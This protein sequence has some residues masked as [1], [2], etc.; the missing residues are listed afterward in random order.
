MPEISYKGK[1]YTIFGAQEKET[2]TYFLIC[3]NCEFRWV[4]AQECRPYFA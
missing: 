4:N 3:I 1:R 2:T